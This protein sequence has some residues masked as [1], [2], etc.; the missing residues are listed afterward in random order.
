MGA[1]MR[2]AW[3][4][5]VMACGGEKLTPVPMTELEQP[6]PAP[7]EAPRSGADG[8]VDAWVADR[9]LPV[10]RANHCAAAFG[11]R[12][13][14]AGG[15]YKPA[16]ATDFV[17]LDDV[18]VAKVGSDGALQEWKLAGRLPAAGVDCVLAVDGATLVLL[19]GLFADNTLN[20]RVWTATLSADGALGTWSE[21]GALPYGRRSLGGV[22]KLR[23]DSLWLNDARLSSEGAA[24]AVLATAT[25]GSTLSA[26]TSTSYAT[27]FRGKPQVAFTDEAA[28]IIGGYGDANAVQASVTA[29]GLGSGPVMETAA[30]P[31]S[32]A[33][34]AAA[35]AD[36]WLF[37]T[38]GRTQLFG[39]QPSAVVWSAK[40]DGLSVTAWKPQAALPEV[41]SNHTATVVGD[42]L[43][44]AGGGAGAG[45]L[46]TVFRARVKR[47]TSA[48]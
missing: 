26:W 27:S 30:L 1:P 48:Q 34:G 31:E 4:L 23:G 2:R 13:I 7:M 32:R 10:A 42:W 22:A 41:R 11:D 20:G 47:V 19:G 33:F 9:A 37:V 45:G 6:G 35:E 44:V 24:E 39:V 43:F 38:G 3:V 28:F 18:Q 17:A 29:I 15:N 12:L 8:T 21:V 36:G 5:L 46:D 16:G 25:L 40:A 14:I